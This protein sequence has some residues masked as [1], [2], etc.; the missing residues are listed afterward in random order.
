M[1]FISF[2]VSSVSTGVAVIDREPSGYLTL[3]HT[4]IISTNPKH[5]VGRRLKD[6]AEAV[7]ILLETYRPDYVVKEQTIA[8]LATQHVLLKF[9]GVL[10]MIASNEGFPK[11]Y[12][13][14][15]TTVKKVVGGHGRA[16]KEAV[17][18]GTTKYINWN[19]PIDL[20][21]DDISDAVAICLT[22][23]DKEFVLVPLGEV[24]KAKEEAM[25]VAAE[26][27]KYLEEES[28]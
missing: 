14:S 4:D 26:A 28:T 8:R 13:Y 3:I 21:I 24:E 19:E 10:E 7:Q 5:N 23:L 27:S 17:L 11:I 6:F 16:T 18:M 12:E 20:V 2:D 22:H 9:A 1:R 15:P 25:V